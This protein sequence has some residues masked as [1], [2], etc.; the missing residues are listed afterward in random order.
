MVKGT[1]GEL[2]NMN[3]IFH[4]LLNTISGDRMIKQPFHMSE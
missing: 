1:I 3:G 4:V 2:E